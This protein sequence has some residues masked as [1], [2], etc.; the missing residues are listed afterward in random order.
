[1]SVIDA[2][3]AAAEL[4]DYTLVDSGAGERLERIGGKLLRRPAQQA[5]WPQDP[6]APWSQADHRFARESTGYGTWHP[7]APADGWTATLGG[8]RVSLR[9]TRFGHL[10]IFPEMA[11]PWA[12]VSERLRACDGQPKLLNLFAYTG[13]LSLMAARAGAAVA[14][15]DAA[16]GTV[17]WARDN[18]QLAGLADAPIRWLTDDA[19]KFVDREARRGNHYQSIVLDPPTFG[20]GARKEVWQ[21][22]SD[23]VPLLDGC[24]R[25][26]APDADHLLLTCHTPGLVGPGLANLLAPLIGDRGGSLVDGELVLRDAGDKALPSGAYALWMR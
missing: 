19:R 8:L 23:L 7:R 17:G 16:K 3:A 18:A 21:I 13:I 12:F 25:L 15:V 11:G 20:R 1:M 6:A 10:G 2:A 9:A 4:G 24:F 26:L 5:I 22:E 14:H